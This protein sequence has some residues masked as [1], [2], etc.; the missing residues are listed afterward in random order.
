MW[1][2]ANKSKWMGKNE[3]SVIDINKRGETN[4]Q[5]LKLENSLQQ[6]PSLIQTKTSKADVDPRR[7]VL[8]QA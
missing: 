7:F 6:F 8:Y 5:V 3:N 1:G 2:G 4:Q